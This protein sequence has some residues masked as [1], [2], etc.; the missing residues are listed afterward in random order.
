MDLA[1]M[2]AD[3]GAADEPA[4]QEIFC[5]PEGDLA[6]VAGPWRIWVRCYP[7]AVG[8]ALPRGGVGGGQDG[9]YPVGFTAGGL[10]K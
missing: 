3:Y 8:A 2:L 5:R 4:P 1:D 9:W 6:S 7:P 10:V